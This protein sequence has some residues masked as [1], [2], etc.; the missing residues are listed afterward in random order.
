MKTRMN[1]LLLLT[2]MS[3]IAMSGCTSSAVA[4]SD[5]RSIDVVESKQAKS[6]WNSKKPLAF[7]KSKK[8]DC[9][10][11]YTTVPGIADEKVDVRKSSEPVY[12]HN[13]S[14][15]SVDTY[16]GNEPAEE[17]Y[18][19]HNSYD[20]AED[21]Y[22]SNNTYAIDGPLNLNDHKNVY[23]TQNT[24]ST[25]PIIESFSNKTAI[26]VGAFRKYAG[27][28]VYAKKYDLLSNRYNVEIKKNVKDNRPLYRVRI[29]GFSN[30]SEAKEFISKYGITEAF[31]VR[32]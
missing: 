18:A 21:P 3:A 29:E 10:D 9:V 31:L 27:A 12:S 4:V 1:K 13:Y 22:A 19:K 30:R 15:K 5:V 14:N 2:T 25:R 28:K 6:T 20:R 26:Q 32:N 7:N 16:D 24:A 17:N 11:C 8:E 23:T